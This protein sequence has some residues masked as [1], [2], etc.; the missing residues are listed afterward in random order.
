[1]LLLLGAAPRSVLA[2][3]ENVFTYGTSQATMLFDPAKHRDETESINIFNTYDSLVRPIRLGAQLLVRPWLAESWTASADAKTWTFK[4]RKGVKFHDGSELTAADVAFSMDRMLKIDQGFS[5]LWKGLLEP[6]DTVATDRYTVVFNLRQPFAIFIPTLVQFHIVN[7]ALCRAQEKNGDLCQDYLLT[8]DAGSG[9]FR[10]ERLQLGQEILFSR[11]ADYFQGPAQLTKV[12]WKVIPER[13]TQ[14]TA[15]KTGAIDAVDQW[16]SPEAYKSLEG[17]PGIVVQRDPQLQ[18]YLHQMH[19]KKPPF[20]DVHCRRAVLYAFDYDT[21][22]E[23]IF[24]GGA[25]AVGPVPV[26]APGWNAALQPY[27]RDV[28][29][30][31]KALAQCKYTPEQLAQMELTYLFVAGFTLEEKLGLLMRENL[32]DIGMKLKL[33][34]LP[35]AQ[36]TE[37]AKTSETTRHFTAIFHTMKIPHPD[38]HTTLMFSP[39]T[40][41]AG[42]SY[43][44]MNWYEHAEA[45]ALMTRARTTVDEAE[46]MQ[47]YARVQAIVH[48]EAAS[49]FIANP[50]HRI[51]FRNRVKGYTFNGVLGYDLLFWQLR[52]ER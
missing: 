23:S 43:L 32:Q 4:L 37:T 5:S 24:R 31:K 33:E 16:L 39:E 38:S 22:I 12:V 8:H 19:T 50:E 49:L 48:T 6:G 27:R 34:S 20:D 14:V 40:R 29:A 51:A 28:E 17:M 44:N 46:Q 7:Q 47:L 1:V 41:T 9:A 21:A 30:A 10:V 11:F 15:L 18:L 26:L 42:G 3:A 35:W 52:V 25:Q 36:I 13:A 45:T 2:Q